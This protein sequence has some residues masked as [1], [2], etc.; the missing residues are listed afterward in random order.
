MVSLEATT[1][2]G[3]VAWTTTVNINVRCILSEE[4]KQTVLLKVNTND[5]AMVVAE[6]IADLFGETKYSISFFYNSSKIN[7]NDRL[8][9]I[10][11]GG[12]GNVTIEDNQSTILCLKGGVD[13]PKIFMRFKQVDSPER[14]LS[15]IAEE[16]A[17]DAITFIPKKDIKFAG[18]SIY[19]VHSFEQD[20]SCMYK[21][22]IGTE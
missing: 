1:P 9:D 6:Q 3:F 2:E 21:I 18:F 13:A 14:Q 12:T 11:I 16:E 20:F 7:L 10:G 8:A 19:Q 4:K 17:Y 22:K 5:K 15:Y